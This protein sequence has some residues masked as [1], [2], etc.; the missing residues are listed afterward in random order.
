MNISDVRD[1]H[2]LRYLVRDQD[3]LFNLAGQTSHLD[4]M[5]DPYTDLEINCRSQLSILEACRRHNP[6]VTDRVREHA[7]DLR[8][9]AAI[10]PSTRS[11]RSRRSTSTASTSWP[12]EWYH[13]LYGD[14][15]GIPRLRPSADEHVRAAH[16]RQGRAADVPR[17][18]APPHRSTARSSTIFG[19]GAQRRDF[20]YVDDAVRAFLLARRR[21]EAVGQVYN[22][23]SPEVVSLASS[24]SCSSR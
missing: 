2:S 17:L 8:P 16:A 15:Y 19:D 18:L 4:S 14:V 1:E 20:N 10:S 12:G 5:D 23:G 13:L 6:E 22:L 24:R 3:Y 7:P 21:D 9:A 11:T